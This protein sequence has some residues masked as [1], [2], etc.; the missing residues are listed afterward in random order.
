MWR[1]RPGRGREGRR[2]IMRILA[3]D[4]SGMP[5]SVAVCEDGVLLAEYTV[6]FKRT[7]S[8]TLLPMLDEVRRM[9][10][11]DLDSIDAVA[12]AG[13]PGSF[14]GL[15]IGSATAKGIGLA[16]G[17]PLV[18]V[19]TLEAMACN[20]YGSDRL[21]VPMMDARRKQVFAGIYTFTEKELEVSG[22]GAEVSS[23][24]AEVSIEEVQSSKEEM[25][26]VHAARQETETPGSDIFLTGV[27]DSLC[28]VQDQEP[29]DV[30]E[31][32][33]KINELSADMEREV[34]LLG[35]GASA[36]RELIEKHLTAPHTYA[37]AHLAQ[38][39]AG[40]VAVR[41]MEM[42]RMG[43][44]ETAQEHR[45]DYLRVS[46]AE[47]VRAQKMGDVSEGV[48]PSDRPGVKE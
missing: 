32:C 36:Y 31:L 25:S 26:A 44:T 16:I 11:L 39:K 5:A 23:E 19:P 43:K 29:V 27:T 46:Q 34:V 41:G 37:P 12:I 48:R 17:K 22:E 7:H 35:D 24:G 40:A 9:L 13:G 14:T 45:P 21:I 1:L 18:H 30:I 10:E 42:V 33:E 47:R 8:Q 28:I 2:I 6:N 15:R 3:I 38:Q 4:S 20:Y